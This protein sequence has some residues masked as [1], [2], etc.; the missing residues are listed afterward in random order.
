MGTHRGF[1]FCL[2][3]G[4]CRSLV[5]TIVVVTES[6]FGFPSELGN[7]IA[8]LLAYLESVLVVH[9]VQQVQECLW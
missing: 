3:S 8:P 1:N 4:L 9:V 2:R 5:L 6:N 7:E